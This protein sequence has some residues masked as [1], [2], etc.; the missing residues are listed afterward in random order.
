MEPK[1]KAMA[2]FL[3]QNQWKIY[4]MAILL[5]VL[6]LI[7]FIV[8]VNVSHSASQSGASVSHP[9]TLAVTVVLHR[10]VTHTTK[11]VYSGTLNNATAVKQIYQEIVSGHRVQPGEVYNC[12]NMSTTYYAYSIDFQQK[13]KTIIQA[14]ADA[15]GCSFWI[16]KDLIQTTQATYVAS[17]NS[18][19]SDLHKYTG[20]PEPS[21]AFHA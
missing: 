3:H 19:W 14:N 10:D 9:D 2:A 20:T 21:Q 11:V 18:L 13:G 7:S 5:L 16:V 17:T 12:P 1:D 6:L 4:L 15:T 8:L